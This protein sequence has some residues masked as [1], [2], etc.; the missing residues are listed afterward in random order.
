MILNV[1]TAQ[2]L[3][4]ISLQ[5]YFNAWGEVASIVTDFNGMVYE[6]DEDVLQAKWEQYVD[7]AQTDLQGIY[8]LIQQSQEIGIKAL[9]AKVSPFLLLRRHTTAPLVP[10]TLQFDFSDFPT[11]EAS[12]LIRAQSV[13]C[14]QPLSP[15]FAEEFE[16]LR[17]GRNKIAHLGLFNQHLD[18]SEMVQLLFDQYRELYP[19]RAWLPDRLHFASAKDRFAGDLIDAGDWSHEGAVLNELWELRQELTDE[20]AAMVFGHSA[21]EQRYICPPCGLALGRHTA[22]SEPYAKDV[23]TAFTNS[24]HSVRCAMCLQEHPTKIGVCADPECEGRRLSAHPEYR[25]ECLSCGHTPED[26]IP[27]EERIK[28][29]SPPDE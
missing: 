25:E 13:F 11:L 28:R 12:E 5:L 2:D 14:D 18:P 17:R 29:Q 15:R 27:W 8:T 19:G 4:T 21:E 16:K 9:I 7:A 24:P 23:P 1:P 10:N 22:G 3:E 6:P 20:Q 26:M